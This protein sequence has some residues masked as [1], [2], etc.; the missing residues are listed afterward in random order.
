MLLASVIGGLLMI[1]EL[2]TDDAVK[3]MLSSRAFP[4]YEAESNDVRPVPLGERPKSRAGDRESVWAHE[5]SETELTLKPME[6]DQTFNWA[7]W[8][9]VGLL[10][11]CIIGLLVWAYLRL[12][13]NKRKTASGAS[14]RSLTDSIEH[15]PFQVDTSGDFLAAAGQAYRAGDYR[16]A[17]IY[18]YSHVLVT[19]DQSSIIR[20][21]KGRTNGQYLGDLARKA[22]L[23]GYFGNVMEAFELVFFGDHEISKADFESV[24]NRYPGFEEEIRKGMASQAGGAA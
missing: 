16:K 18:L 5:A 19:L 23:A 15:L 20:L 7:F 24:W 3:Q 12:E 6:I 22:S 14:R 10:L 8:I 9:V 1:S 11:V 2:N 17:T 13:A 21:R 4:W